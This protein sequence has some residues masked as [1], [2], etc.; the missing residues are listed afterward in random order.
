MA[1][2][3][4]VYGKLNHGGKNI[5]AKLGRLYTPKFTLGPLIKTM[6][7]GAYVQWGDASR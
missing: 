7:H 2:A 5:L 4:G 6:G 1:T 3:M